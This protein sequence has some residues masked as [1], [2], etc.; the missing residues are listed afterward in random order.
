MYDLKSML[1]DNT[2]IILISLSPFL[3]PPISL[4]RIDYEVLLIYLIIFQQLRVKC[5]CIGAKFSINF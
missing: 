1:N 3:F 4:S 5:K 2:L